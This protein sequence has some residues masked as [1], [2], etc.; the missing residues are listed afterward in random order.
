MGL[1]PVNPA[2]RTKAKVSPSLRAPGRQRSSVS[3]AFELS[4]DRQ[5]KASENP[6]WLQLSVFAD[7]IANDATDNSTT[8]GSNRTATGQHCAANRTG[9]R[10]NHCV[11][12]PR[13]HAPA[14][15]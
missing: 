2:N 1:D 15:G 6:Q 13:R 12:I 3:I 9:T 14:T 11:L 4:A 8:Y 7:L 5:T 10:T